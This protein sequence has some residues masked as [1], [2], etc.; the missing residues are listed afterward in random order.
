MDDA[1]NHR[2]NAKLK[3]K[4]LGPGVRWKVQYLLGQSAEKPVRRRNQRR[5]PGGGD[6]SLTLKGKEPG[7]R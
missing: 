2:R 1:V 7:G 6:L 3:V 5:L 4:G